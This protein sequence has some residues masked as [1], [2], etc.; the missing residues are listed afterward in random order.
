MEIKVLGEATCSRMG[1]GA[2]CGV[3]QGS[4]EPAHFVHLIYEG[5][6]QS[7]DHNVWLLGKSI[8]FDSGGL[9]LKDVDGYASN[10]G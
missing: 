2:F 6:A 8:T 5:H 10:E 7:Q 4:D 9:S 3:A 1:M